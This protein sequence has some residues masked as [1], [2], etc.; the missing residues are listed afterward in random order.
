MKRYFHTIALSLVSIITFLVYSNHFYNAFHFDDFHTIVEN[1]Y[2][3]DIKNIPSFFLNAETTSTLPANQAYRPGLTTL[4]TIDYYLAGKSSAEPFVFHVSIFIGFL[5]LGI[6]CYFTFLYLLQKSLDYQS[7]NYFALFATA[8]F[9]LH[10][11][12]AETINYIIARSDSFSTLTIIL[13]FILYFYFPKSQKIYLYFIP[14]FLGFFVKELTMMFIPLLVVYK[15]LFEQ[16]L[17]VRQWFLSKNYTIIK[18]VAFPLLLA[19]ALFIFSR[20]MTPAHWDSGG[21]SVLKYLFTQPFVIFHYAYNFVLPLNLVVDTDWSVIHSYTDDRI[22]AGILFIISLLA[23]AYQCS[24]DRKNRPITF[25][26][27]WFFIA[28]FPTSSIFPFAEVLNDHRT[29]FPYIGLFIAATTFLRNFIIEHNLFEK[30]ASKWVILTSTF[31]FLSLHGY[32]THQRNKIWAT[33]ETLWQECT[34]KSPKNGRGWMNY[35]LAL[36]KKGDYAN[37]MMCYQKTIT[38]WPSYAYAYIN[39]AI[40]KRI[41][42]DKAMAE[43]YFK[44]SFALNPN[45][46]EAYAFYA[47]FLIASKRITEANIFLEKGLS[48][49]PQHQRL[50]SL[51]HSFLKN[52]KQNNLSAKSN[53]TPEYYI[54]LSLQ[55]YNAGDFQKCIAAAYE[56]LKLKPNY[57]LAYNNICAAYNQLGAYEK[58][59]TIGEKGMKIN[60]KN[61][62]L[63]GNLAEAYQKKTK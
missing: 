5:L 6:L 61:Q 42:G 32:G 60:P 36:M 13:S 31:V 37:A 8:W 15:L 19:I 14:A 43:A 7:N 52:S 27:L 17:L 2:I 1:L 34:I 45:I 12:N 29:F 20:K 50:L 48:L 22:L 49:S 54:D 53:L 51:K 21:A 59:I 63:K 44:K 28:L 33:E 23:I 18:Q 9:L 30:A 39:M 25:G 26:I 58:A 4:N 40:A 35:G 46:P 62:L 38:I 57:D 47:E 10:T 55:Y 41:M 24:F 56:A 16:Q 3:R 11:A